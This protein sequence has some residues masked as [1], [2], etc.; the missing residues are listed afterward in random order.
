MLRARILRN[1]PPDFGIKLLIGFDGET[2]YRKG[3]FYSERELN[4]V[5]ARTIP[6]ASGELISFTTEALRLNG[7]RDSIPPG[8]PGAWEAI[9]QGPAIA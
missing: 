6:S 4:E 8:S 5:L 7:I 3:R 1:D 2:Q 9:L